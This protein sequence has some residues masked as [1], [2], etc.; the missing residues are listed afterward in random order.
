MISPLP[1]GACTVSVL[2]FKKFPFCHLG[3][4]LE[5]LS[6]L[7]PGFKKEWELVA[8][9]QLVCRIPKYNALQGPSQPALRRGSQGDEGPVRTY[10]LCPHIRSRVLKGRR[11]QRSAESSLEALAA[12]S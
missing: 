8:K 4:T 10:E 1:P 3:Q 12:C 2:Y 5:C 6:H 11:S 7:N 9:C